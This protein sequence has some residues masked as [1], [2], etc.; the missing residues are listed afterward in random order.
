MGTAKTVNPAEPKTPIALPGLVA[1]GMLLVGGAAAV[2]FSWPGHWSYDS[3]VELDQGRSG[4]YNA[5]HPPV[6]AWLLGLADRL[7]R[8]GALF[9]VLEG[10]LVFASL[11]SLALM[12][13]RGGW[14]VV[15]AAALALATPQLAIYP[16]IVWKDVL[17]AG[18]ALAAFA[19]LAWYGR[20]W[21]SPRLRWALLV[22][23][24]ALLALAALARQNGLILIP[25]AAVTAGWIAARQ[26]TARP[27]ARGVAAGAVLLAVAIGVA[28]AGSAA[29][30]TRSDGQNERQRQWTELR[31]Y[32]M[33]AAR[34]L[35][36][37]AGFPILAAR[38]PAMNAFLLG[39]GPRLF[40]TQR[41]DPLVQN[42][43]VAAHEDA[44]RPAVLAQWRAI[45][46]ARPWLYLR[47]RAELFRQ[48]F[49]APDIEACVPLSVGVNGPPEE[50]KR[51]GFETRYSDADDV[52]FT[53][54]QAFFH[55]PVFSH[56]AWAL[57]AA[58][59]MIA[60][61]LRRRPEDLAV[62]GLLAAA[63]TF[64]A[65][66]FAISIACDYRYLY[67]LDLSALAGAV[68]AAGTAQFAR[69]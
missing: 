63:L 64:T 68:Y 11:A 39:Q 67:F 5:W 29:L 10:A 9:T 45:F 47:V 59:L 38:A 43:T 54:A 51:L 1:A 30:K 27:W 3:V 28:V 35:D 41:I 18:A 31:L 14:A 25:V 69:R 13:R 20:G 32:E 46:A 22:K 52:V 7:Q 19:C 16:A 65:S 40:N 36:P 15:A 8:G 4:I 61:L 21:P 17:F 26:A 50:M 55:S 2:A 57:L 62:A 44:D 58:A 42:D 34:Q 53:Y 33:V 49:A 66:F 48:V 6:T 12:A 37:G 60:L 23:A 24:G 56:A